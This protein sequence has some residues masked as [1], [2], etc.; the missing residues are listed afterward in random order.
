MSPLEKLIMKKKEEGRMM[1]PLEQKAKMGSLEALRD[2]M[3]GMMKDDL[4]PKAEVKVAADSPEG[5]SEGLEK[6]QDLVEDSH[7]P[8]DED[9]A[10]GDEVA[11]SEGGSSSDVLS[12]EERALLEKLL[13]KAKRI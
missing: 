9:Q 11:D 13:A 3:S 12:D 1:D 4:A 10:E 7:E 6:A 8:A 5:L 2:E